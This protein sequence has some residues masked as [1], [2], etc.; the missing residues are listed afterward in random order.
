[1][2][3]DLDNLHCHDCPAR[4][5]RDISHIKEMECMREETLDR[6]AGR[7]ARCI[8]LCESIPARSFIYDAS[9]SSQLRENLRHELVG[10]GSND[11]LFKFM[12]GH[13]IWLVDCA[14]CPLYKLTNNSDRRKAATICLT[15]HTVAYLRAMPNA[16]LIAISPSNCGF[17]KRQLPSI[18]S[19]V[20]KSYRFHNLKGL[21][22]EFC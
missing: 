16:K 3:I 22:Q 13:A 7:S 12:D 19:R 18:A 14:L 10:G 4:P 8:L 1:M 11:V 2:F 9:S 6:L 21:K 17:L 20:E 5:L 15:R